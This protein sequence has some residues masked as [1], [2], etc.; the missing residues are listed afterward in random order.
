[1]ISHTSLHYYFPPSA[2]KQVEESVPFWAKM[3]IFDRE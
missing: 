2:G 1:M 3:A